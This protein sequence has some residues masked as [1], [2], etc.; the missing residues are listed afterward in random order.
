MSQEA[1]KFAASVNAKIC[2]P[3]DP[4]RPRDMLAKTDV[5]KT[6]ALYRS[7]YAPIPKEPAE[8]F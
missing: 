1:V 3:L 5:Q 8:I 2:L 4:K 7:P 6:W